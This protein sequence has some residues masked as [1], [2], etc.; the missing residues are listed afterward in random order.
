M[1]FDLIQVDFDTTREEVYILV[2]PNR[3]SRLEF[4]VVV[5]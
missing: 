4:N 3:R 5:S 1:W 2:Q